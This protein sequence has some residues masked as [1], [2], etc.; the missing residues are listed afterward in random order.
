MVKEESLRSKNLYKVF[1]VALKVLPM[2]ISL[3]YLLNTITAYLGYNIEIF[4]FIGGVS[5]LPWIFL[6]ISAVVFRFCMYHKM[7]LFY[8]LSDDVIN[9]LD[10][11]FDFTTAYEFFIIHMSIAGVF[12]FLILYLYKKRI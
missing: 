5:L 3:C 9:Y 11:F 7:F 2:L 12:L 1:L 6:Y 8:I 10:Y 4:S